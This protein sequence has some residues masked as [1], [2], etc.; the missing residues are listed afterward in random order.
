MATTPAERKAL[1]FLGVVAALGVGARVVAGIRGG[2]RVGPMQPAL[3]RQLA[4]AEGEARRA[5]AEREAKAAGKKTARRK[6]RGGSTRAGVVA[7]S[8]DSTTPSGPTDI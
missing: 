8:G 2:D 5:R 7:R 3:E 6:E 1:I 4:R